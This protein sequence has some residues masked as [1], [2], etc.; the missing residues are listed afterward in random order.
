MT[1][2]KTILAAAVLSASLFATAEASEIKPLQGVSFHAGTKH[3]VAY[4]LNENGTCK[5]VVT[6]A[7]DANF[8]P[9]R[10]ETAVAPHSS[11][12][13]RLTEGKA[14]E[15]TCEDG[16]RSMMVKEQETTAAN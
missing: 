8:A 5:L 15:F 4:F 6:S 10:I 2:I 13:Q 16:A 14:I 7:D 11:N 1:S 9:V 3:A 12:L